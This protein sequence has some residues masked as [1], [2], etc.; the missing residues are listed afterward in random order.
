MRRRQLALAALAALVTASL[1]AASGCGTS[2]LVVPVLPPLSSVTLTPETDTLLVGEQRQF[3]AAAADTDS[4]AVPGATFS[5]SSSDVSVF[6]VSRTGRVTAMGEGIARLVAA[7]G[8]K[9]DTAIV[10]VLYQAGWYQQA[11]ATANDLNGVF[12]QPDGR[13]GVAVGDAGTVVRTVDAGRSWFNE[14]SST[15]F[16]LNDVWF[17]TAETGFAVGNGGTVMRTRNGGATW[18]RLTGVP[19][20]E[21]LMGV[22]FADTSRGWA[23]GANGVIVR[24]TNGG[25]SWTR[26]NPT[27]QQLNSVSFSDALEGWAVGDGGVILGTHDGGA[28]W[29]IVQ[30]SLTA[31]PL[32]SV[33]RSSATRAWAGGA[34]GANP[35]TVA[36][37]DSLQ[38]VLGTFGALNHVNGLQLP[39]G[40]TGYAVGTNGQGLVLKTPDGGTSWLPQVSNTAQTLH[41]VWFVDSR[42]GWAVGA[43]GRI[44]HTANG[45]E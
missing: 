28:S 31:L 17:T 7:A 42:R 37:P 39:D 2:V 33:W 5:W 38:W 11:S 22:C 45:G 3:V 21:N 25:A 1:L 13:F 41:D 9:A 19:A 26:S 29:Y 32:R 15:A 36:T 34:Q 23:V 18:T 27:A 14:P 35:F 43:T 12:F 24:T 4:V 6:Q 30:P 8:G 44:I 40:V 20:A 10:V 16:N